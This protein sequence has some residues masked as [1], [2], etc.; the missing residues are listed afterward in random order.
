MNACRLQAAWVV[1][2]ALIRVAVDHSR[3][4]A[5]F[6]DNSLFGDPRIAR[7]ERKPK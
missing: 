2:C 4:F 1:G 6:A 7:I 3:Q 5:K